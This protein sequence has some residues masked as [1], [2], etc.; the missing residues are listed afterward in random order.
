MIGTL[1]YRLRTLEVE[2]ALDLAVALPAVL[3]GFDGHSFAL[4]TGMTTTGILESNLKI[5][6]SLRK[7]RMNPTSDF[8]SNPP[9]KVRV[10]SAIQTGVITGRFGVKSAA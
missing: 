7:L 10:D 8:D 6:M 1:F 9:S 4:P 3:M 5:R 2:N